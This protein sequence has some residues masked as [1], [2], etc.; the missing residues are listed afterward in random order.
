LLALDRIAA[1]ARVPYGDVVAAAEKSLVVALV[2]VD[3]VI[4]VAADERVGA[5]AA[6]DVVV[7]VAAVERE[8]Y[9]SRQSAR[10]EGVVTAQ[11]VDGKAVVG[12]FRIYD[13]HL[14][15]QAVYLHHAIGRDDVDEVPE[16]A[17]VAVVASDNDGIASGV[18]GPV[19]TKIDVDRRHIKSGGEAVHLDGV[20]AAERVQRDRLDMDEVHRDVNVAD[21]AGDA[22]MRRVGRKGQDGEVLRA[23][24]AV[25]EQGVGVRASVD[26]IAAVAGVP[27]E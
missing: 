3:E 5:V 2:A 9:Q 4:A 21:I 22:K 27:F 26:D 6:V 11:T 13:V 18:A 25:E 20:G 23:R 8:L 1:V 15:V 16:T 10:Y 12:R 7:A 19:D 17:V 14:S 24:R